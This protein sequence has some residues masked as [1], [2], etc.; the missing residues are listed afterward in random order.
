MDHQEPMGSLE[1]KENLVLL[2][3][4]ALLAYKVHLAWLVKLDLKDPLV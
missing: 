3:H 2:G 4:Q 1:T